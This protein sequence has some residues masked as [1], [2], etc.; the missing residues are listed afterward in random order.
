M[1]RAKVVRSVEGAAS[2]RENAPKMNFFSQVGSLRSK[3]WQHFV[4]AVVLAI[5]FPLLPLALEWGLS[6]KVTDKTVLISAIMYC[7][8]LFVVSR[9]VV[10]FALGFVASILLSVLF[11]ITFYNGEQGPANSS[12]LSYICIVFFAIAHMFRCYDT[13]VVRG[14]NFIEFGEKP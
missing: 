10:I 13:H 3:N 11:G 7:S 4:G 14:Q 2:R 9:S 6:D 5:M 12:T 8:A 1:L